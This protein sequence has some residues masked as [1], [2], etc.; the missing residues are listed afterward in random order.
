MISVAS[1]STK[2]TDLRRKALSRWDNEGG[3]LPALTESFHE[4]ETTDCKP[5]LAGVQAG[6]RER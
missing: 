6:A 3:A 1:P 5:V 4:V 2:E